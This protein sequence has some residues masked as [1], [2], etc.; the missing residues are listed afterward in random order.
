MILTFHLAKKKK[1]II[2]PLVCKAESLQ[3]VQ[4]LMTQTFF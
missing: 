1:K 3:M 2:L 4:I